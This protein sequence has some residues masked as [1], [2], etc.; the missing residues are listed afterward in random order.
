MHRSGITGERCA[1][2]FALGLLIFNPPLLSIFGVP[3]F[4]AGVPVFFLYIFLAW[5]GLIVLLALTS[6]AEHKLDEAAPEQR[7]PTNSQQS[8]RS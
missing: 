8:G 4:L 3:N 2:L 6:R 7:Y 5:G 1:A